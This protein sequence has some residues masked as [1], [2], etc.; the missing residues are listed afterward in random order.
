MGRRIIS[1][2]HYGFI[3][4]EYKK[5]YSSTE[6]AK[7]FK[8]NAETIRK[9]LKINKIERR[10]SN[11]VKPAHTKT[12]V[13]TKCKRRYPNN[14]NYFR[15][16]GHKYKDGE[17][18]LKPRCKHCTSKASSN[19]N[20]S[21]KDKIIRYRKKYYQRDSV[22]EQTRKYQK[23]HPWI[24]KNYR[25]KN[26]I[27]IKKYRKGWR[28]KNADKI[29]QQNKRY[30]EEHTEE[31]KIYHRKR[32]E[33]DPKYRITRSLR[34][35]LNSALKWQGVRKTKH[36]LDLI[37][38]SVDFLKKHIESQFLRGMTWDNYGREGWSID[39]IIP[40]A[41]FDLVK[42][43]DQ[44]RCFNYK[45]LRPLWEVDNWKKNS[46]HNGTYIRKKWDKA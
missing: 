20:K 7:K 22:K 11:N 14:V 42:I 9:I 3:I 15:K 40:C 34:T 13:C 16:K 26:K 30:R 32:M 21:H 17:E 1:T 41:S 29:R 8:C 28:L 27:R 4:S 19:Y 45:N 23:E 5:G 18:K 25:R 2:E 10:D 46:L 44:K 12:K 35:R 31:S 43:K 37:G 39:H 6:L 38:C 33:S 36:T 24:A